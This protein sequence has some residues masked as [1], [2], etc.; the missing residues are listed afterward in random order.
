MGRSFW[1]GVLAPLNL[2]RAIVLRI[3]VKSRS[4]IL[5]DSKWA[6][7]FPIDVNPVGF[8]LD[9]DALVIRSRHQVFAH[10]AA[11][12]DFGNPGL[13]RDRFPFERRSN[14]SD[15]V[16]ADDP[17]GS[18]LEIP[19]DRPTLGG[20]MFNRDL[21]HPRDI[22]QVADVPQFV[23]RIPGNSEGPREKMRRNQWEFCRHKVF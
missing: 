10:R 5:R 20:G 14:V 11:L 12:F 1:S 4:Q 2:I 17:N 8:S 19:L 15:K 18:A 21:L 13:K 16:R 6:P 23:D 9:Q 22:L 3:E 7:A